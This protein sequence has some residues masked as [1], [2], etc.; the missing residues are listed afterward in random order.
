MSPEPS[1]GGGPLTRRE[2]GMKLEAS[3]NGRWGGPSQ[4]FN[5]L[6][7]KSPDYDGFYDDHGTDQLDRRY[8]LLARNLH[9]CLGYLY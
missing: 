9:G 3:T 4:S 7:P 1:T 2:A 8:F 5:A 6:S